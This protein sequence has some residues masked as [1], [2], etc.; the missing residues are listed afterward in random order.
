VSLTALEE[1]EAL[2]EAQRE[3]LMADWDIYG[4]RGYWVHLFE[5]GVDELDTNLRAMR[6]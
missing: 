6:M 2:S 4:Q 3:G 1:W 5:Q